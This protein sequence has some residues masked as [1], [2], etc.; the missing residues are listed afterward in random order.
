[1]VAYAISENSGRF[2]IGDPR[3]RRALVTSVDLPAHRRLVAK[4]EAA[5]SWEAEF[6]TALD[7]LTGPIVQRSPALCRRASAWLVSAAPLNGCTGHCPQ[8]GIPERPSGAIIVRG[9]QSAR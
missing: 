9:E 1:V 4:L 6:E 8:G 2:A 7:D 5:P 3:E